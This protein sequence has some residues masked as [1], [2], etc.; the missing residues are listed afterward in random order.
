ML[1]GDPKADPAGMCR[2]LRSL[3]VK[4]CALI[5][6]AFKEQLVPK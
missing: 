3:R 1:R 5:P 6:G 4:V 2:K